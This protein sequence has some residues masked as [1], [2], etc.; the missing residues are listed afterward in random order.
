MGTDVYH[1][2]QL[3]KHITNK[4]K[5]LASKDSHVGTTCRE[6]ARCCGASGSSLIARV[7]PAPG[8]NLRSFWRWGRNPREDLGKEGEKGHL[9]IA[10][11]QNHKLE[12]NARRVS[13]TKARA[14][15]LV[16]LLR[17][18]TFVTIGNIQ[19]RLAWPLRKDDT[20]NREANS[21]FLLPAPLSFGR[22][23]G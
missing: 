8:V 9:R 16:S 21:N 10:T 14:T 12:S 13:H 6:T 3:P 5:T 2:Y 17:K 23:W 20:Q 11:P 1:I 22:A 18:L 15:I 4:A 19:R 7:S